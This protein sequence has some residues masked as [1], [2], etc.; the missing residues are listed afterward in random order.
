MLLRLWFLLF[1][2]VGASAALGK[3]RIPLQP[4]IDAA[5]DNAILSLEPGVYAGP[6]I[7]DHPLTIDGQGHATIDAGGVGS[8]VVLDT[9]GAQLRNLR[10]VGS[11]GSHNDI[12]SA[13][14]VRGNFNVIKDNVIE[15]TLFGI[16]LQ[17]SNNNIVRRNR[18]RSKDRELGLRGDAIRL[19][20]SFK[21]QVTDNTITDSRDTVV[22]YSADNTIARNST[23]RGRYALHF[24]YSRHNLV[25]SNRYFNNS[26]GIFLMYSDGVVVRDNMIAHAVGATGVGI[27]FKETS[28]VTIEDNRVLYCATGLYLDVSPYDPDATN[29]IEGNL[30]AYNGIGVRFLNDWKGNT[31][32]TNRFKG[33]LT[34]VAVNGNGSAR[35]NLWHGNYWD[36]YEGFDRDGDGIGDSPYE[37]YAY[38]DRVWMDVPGAQFFKGSPTLEV[39]DFLERLAPFS[40]PDLILRDTQPAMTAERFE[41]E[42]T[43]IAAH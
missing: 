38:A 40:E 15:D 32:R 18:I 42:P 17:Q 34:Q 1:T 29:R 14:Q 26:V 2:L 33:N 23:T 28:D 8:V 7:V 9:D 31:F 3:E 10:L 16:D 35:R 6:V 39:L 22:W 43:T 4:L 41:D 27:G 24:M 5:D 12:D 25:E 11:G 21:N 37:A 19:W 36:D 20:Y 13:V 30:I